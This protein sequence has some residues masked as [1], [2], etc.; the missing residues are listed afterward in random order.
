MIRSAATGETHGSLHDPQTHLLVKTTCCTSDTVGDSKNIPIP[1]K[2]LLSSQMENSSDSF[3]PNIIEELNI[4]DAIQVLGLDCDSLAA[5]LKISVRQVRDTV[6]HMMQRCRAQAEQEILDEV[7]A[8]VCKR[9]K[10]EEREAIDAHEVAPMSTTCPYVPLRTKRGQESDFI[11]E[12]SREIVSTLAQNQETN[13]NT[14]IGKH[15][16]MSS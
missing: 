3:R 7:P 16:A 8:L 1:N 4:L 11:H 15:S 12:R 14:I 5:H 2:S 9:I 6:D 10:E 13:E